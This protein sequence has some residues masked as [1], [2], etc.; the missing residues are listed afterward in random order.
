MKKIDWLSLDGKSLRVFLTVI[1]VGTITGAADKL[2]IT[3]SAV[4]HTIEKLREVVGDP[5]FIR[6]GRTIAP[7]TY[8]QQMAEKVEGILGEMKDLVQMPSFSPI[9][10]EID[11]VVAANDFQSS[12]LMPCF[13]EQVKGKLKRFTLKVI[14]PQIPTVE[15][16]R[17]KKC[18]LAIAGFSPDSSDIMQKKLFNMHTVV[19]YDPSMRGA[20][21]DMEDYLDSK[22][23]GLSFLQNYKGGV[24]AFLRSRG[25]RRRVEISVP[26]FSSIATYLKGTEMLATLPSLM[27]LIEMKDFAFAPLP[28]YFST[29]KMNMIWHQSYQYDEPHKWLRKEMIEVVNSLP[30]K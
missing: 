22:H 17:E 9:E 4:S 16:I 27:R 23:L 8:A 14:S 2:G 19:F 25:Q 7:T 20:P 10:S 26:N 3:Q 28:F 1:E 13:Y 30:E 11:L 21:E 29:G 18:T 24:D 5:L 15:L 12:L 6:A